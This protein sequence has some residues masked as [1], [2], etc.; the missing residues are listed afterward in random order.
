MK[1]TIKKNLAPQIKEEYQPH[2]IPPKKGIKQERDSLHLNNQS[3]D[4][5]NNLNEPLKAHNEKKPKKKCC[6][7]CCS[8]TQKQKRKII[9]IVL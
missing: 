1:T 9:F 3:N 4:L 2:E 5:K 7:F 8:T 6:Y